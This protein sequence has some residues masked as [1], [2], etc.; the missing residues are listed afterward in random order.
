MT[1]AVCTL[2]CIYVLRACIIIEKRKK[3]LREREH[4][5]IWKEVKIIAKENNIVKWKFK[6]S[7]AITQE[8][9][10]NLLNKK[11]ERN[12]ISDIWSAIITQIKVN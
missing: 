12:V 7:V 3:H 9:K 6:E 10:D 5:P 4:T 8:K 1:G 11:E 2:C